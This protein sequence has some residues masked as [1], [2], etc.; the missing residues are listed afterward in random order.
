MRGVESWAATS[1]ARSACAASRSRACESLSG[2]V[3]VRSGCPPDATSTAATSAA[4]TSST[5]TSSSTGT[6][7]HGP[8]KPVRDQHRLVGLDEDG[9]H[10]AA[11][12]AVGQSVAASPYPTERG[13][14]TTCREGVS[15][16]RDRGSG[17]EARRAGG[18][19]ALADDQQ[20]SRVGPGKR[21]RGAA[22]DDRAGALR[23]APPATR[24]HV[25]PT[26]G[27]GPGRPR[28]RS[29]RASPSSVASAA[30]RRP[31]PR[32]RGRSAGRAAPRSWRSRCRSRR[33]PRG[34]WPRPIRMGRYA[35]LIRT[36]RGRG[37]SSSRPRRS[38]TAAAS[39]TSAAVS[40][41]GVESSVSGE[42]G[43]PVRRRTVRTECLVES[44][45][46]V[47]GEQRE[48]GSTAEVGGELRVVV[49]LGDP[50]LRLQGVRVDA[51]VVGT[52]LVEG[53]PVGGELGRVAAGER[54]GHRTTSS[55]SGAT[56]RDT[57]SRSNAT[58]AMTLVW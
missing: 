56:P 4:R 14:N 9:H 7:P 54:L 46:L 22:A 15:P 6:G 5:G 17:A 21:H 32:L 16:S 18:P 35:A 1:D 39:R 30:A 53:E 49:R 13:T 37:L 31:A 57:C 34:S 55:S 24:Q 45:H 33:R 29:T 20:S 28:P 2:S 40:G 11:A 41:A 50:R 10:G 8:S 3:S 12:D 23:R 36:R 19:R 26:R 38:Y 52:E 48:L 44:H 47:L 42:S 43:E 58:S 51:D 27:R 25:T